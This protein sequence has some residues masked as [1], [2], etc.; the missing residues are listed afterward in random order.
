MECSI[1]SF[2]F[3]NILIFFYFFLP[4]PFFSLNS[5]AKLFQGT[6]FLFFFPT[7]KLILSGFLFCKNSGPAF[8]F[9][10]SS[11]TPPP[12]KKKSNALLPKYT[13]RQKLSA[14][15]FIL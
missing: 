12:P 7:Q 6:P 1:L 5:K 15:L 4:L 2:S 11:Y 8:L 14:T 3:A 9:Q 13:L 10:I